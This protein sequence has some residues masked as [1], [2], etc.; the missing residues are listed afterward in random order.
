VTSG[1]TRRHTSPTTTRPTPA[2]PGRIDWV[3]LDIG[4][5]DHSHLISPDDQLRAALTT[6]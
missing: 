3:Q 5:D 1:R 6:Q 2:S 4:D